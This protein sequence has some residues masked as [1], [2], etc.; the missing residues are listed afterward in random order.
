MHL[1]VDGIDDHRLKMLLTELSKCPVG[2]IPTSAGAVSLRLESCN[3][4]VTEQGL[5]C[6]K[7]SLSAISE[8]VLYNGIIHRDEDVL[9]PIAEAMQAN[10]SLTKLRLPNMHLHHTKQNSSALTKMLQ[11][12]KSLTQLDLSRNIQI[13]DS[14]AR[15]MFE[16]LQHNTTLVSFESMSYR[17][18]SY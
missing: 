10:T 12:N 4:S 15:C 11:V 5:S 8:L 17:Y 13:S 7:K 16:G 6:I 2:G 1:V 14:G 9:L 18:D 3:P